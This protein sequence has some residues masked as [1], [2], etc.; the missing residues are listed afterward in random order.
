MLIVIFHE[1]ITV[2][3]F[4]AHQIP[5]ETDLRCFKK[6]GPGHCQGI[7]FKIFKVKDKQPCAQITSIV[8]ST[9]LLL[10]FRGCG[11]WIFIQCSWLIATLG[12]Y[13]NQHCEEP[14]WAFQTVEGRSLIGYYAALYDVV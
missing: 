1:V 13:M 11:G 9:V 2:S 10:M 4:L 14:G 8:V 6:L 5:T 7:P 3:I 12:G